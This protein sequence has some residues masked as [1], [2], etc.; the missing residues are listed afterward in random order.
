MTLDELTEELSEWARSARKAFA[1]SVPPDD[2]FKAILALWIEPEVAVNLDWRG[3]LDALL[4]ERVISR[5]A[6]YLTL[7]SRQATRGGGS[8]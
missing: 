5:A 4:A 1:G 2:T 3:A 6:R 7:R 8:Q